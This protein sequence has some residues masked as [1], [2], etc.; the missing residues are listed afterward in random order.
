MK[1]DQKVLH[2]KYIHNMLYC[3][4]INECELGV[5]DQNCN[6]TDGSFTCSCEEGYTM[7]TDN[8]SCDG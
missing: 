4:D 3:I 1:Q 2:C 8:R 6:N 5:C 7:N